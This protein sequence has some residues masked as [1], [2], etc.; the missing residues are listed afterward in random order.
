MR[1]SITVREFTGMHAAMIRTAMANK[2]REPVKALIGR[3]IG[4]PV[5]T[6]KMPQNEGVGPDWGIHRAV[7]K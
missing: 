3:S 7:Y 5:I 4:K 2:T 1:I 6:V